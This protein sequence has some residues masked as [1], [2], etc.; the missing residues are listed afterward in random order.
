MT[1]LQGWCVVV[2]ALGCFVLPRIMT[3]ARRAR[4]VRGFQE[5][6]ERWQK[7]LHAMDEHAMEL[8]VRMV[9]EEWE[10]LGMSRRIQ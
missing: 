2:I 6:F 8:R 3:E 7:A 4:E 5:G 9:E 1:P 10:A